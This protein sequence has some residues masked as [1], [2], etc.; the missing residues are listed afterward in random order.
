MLG[1][2]LLVALFPLHLLLE[3]RVDLFGVVVVVGESGVDLGKVEG[4]YSTSIC[5][6]VL[7]SLSRAAMFMTR[8]RVSSIT[9]WPPHTPG[10]LVMCE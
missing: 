7:P 3:G 9:G 6:G 5:S 8:T 4:G 2:N 10:V 1:P